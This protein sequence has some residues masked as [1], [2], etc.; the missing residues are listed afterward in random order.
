V[1]PSIWVLAK[2]IP[3][4]EAVVL[5]AYLLIGVPTGFMVAIAAL[6]LT[7]VPGVS[8]RLRRIVAT[9]ALGFAG[10]NAI[11]AVLWY[12]MDRNPVTAGA[13]DLAWMAALAGAVV[14]A[15]IA[16]FRATARKAPT[17]R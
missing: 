5:S 4:L 9:G 16:T 13:E 2:A 8:L 17:P 11:L 1:L 10:L 7:F 15:A 3:P 12:R 6:A 14:A